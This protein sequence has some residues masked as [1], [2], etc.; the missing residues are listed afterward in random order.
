MALEG[1]AIHDQECDKVAAN[2][3]PNPQRIRFIFCSKQEEYAFGVLL[4][5]AAKNKTYLDLNSGI[6]RDTGCLV[7]CFCNDIVFVFVG[8]V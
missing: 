4:L 2:G 3:P 5:L 6:D 1:P 8:I 7:Y